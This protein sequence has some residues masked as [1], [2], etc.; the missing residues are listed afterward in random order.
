[1]RARVSWVRV[2][3]RV[4]A[5]VRARV[6]VRVRDAAAP[7][8]FEVEGHVQRGALVQVAHLDVGEGAAAAEGLGG[9]EGGGALGGVEGGG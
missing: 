5:R 3:V 7:V 6:R 9:G 4:R 2:Q 8:L 1:M